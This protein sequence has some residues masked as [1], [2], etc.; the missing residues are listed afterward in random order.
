MISFKEKVPAATGKIVLGDWYYP[1]GIRPVGGKTAVQ[2]ISKQISA[3][4]AIQRKLGL[5]TQSLERKLDP[6]I[7]HYNDLVADTLG[8]PTRP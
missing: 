1:K 5:A 6:L 3:N 7:I 8:Q 4:E 2:L